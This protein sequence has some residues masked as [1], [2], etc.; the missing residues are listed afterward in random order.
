MCK[1]KEY[2]YNRNMKYTD[3]YAYIQNS[4]NEKC[5]K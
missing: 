4:K 2:I 3:I 5:H 1:N